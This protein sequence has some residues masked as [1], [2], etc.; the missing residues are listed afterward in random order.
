MDAVRF[1]EK[2]ASQADVLSLLRQCD[3]QFDPP[4]HERVDLDSYAEKLWTHAVTFE[5]WAENCL[6]GLTAIYL[7]DPQGRS[8]YITHVSVASDFMNRGIAHQLMRLCLRKS[9]AQHFESV[10]LETS[11]KNDQAVA[12]YRKLGF[13]ILSQQGDTLRM[14]LDLSDADFE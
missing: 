7:N 10:T 9:V 12:F 3:A 2:T 11:G 6:I 4:L 8:G 1:E 5:A 13:D 14:K